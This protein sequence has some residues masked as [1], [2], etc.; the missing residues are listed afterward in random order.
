ML[1]SLIYGEQC[2]YSLDWTGLDSPLTPK[3]AQISAQFSSLVVFLFSPQ[4][5]DSGYFDLCS[6][7]ANNVTA[8]V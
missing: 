2:I 8:T 5:S 1:A 4:W 7:L 6:C 3:M